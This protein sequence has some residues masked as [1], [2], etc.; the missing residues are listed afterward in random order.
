MKDI[1]TSR[2]NRSRTIT[3][4]VG[5]VGSAIKYEL[6]GDWQKTKRLVNNLETAIAAG[7]IAGQ[8]AAANKIKELV[9]KKIRENGGSTYWPPYSDKYRKFKNKTKPG[10]ANNMLRYTDTYYNNIITWQSG[11]KVHIGLRPRVLVP[12]TNGSNKNITLHEL[13]QIL[14]YG[15]DARNIQ[16]RPLW[17]PVRKEFGEAKVK[18]LIIWHIR[19]TIRIRTGVSAKISL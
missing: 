15:S 6:T 5:N 10:K 9:K 13:A 3:R 16:A 18:A 7:A 17:G 4:T 1:K 2:V 19:N 8:L 12:N 11:T 14:E